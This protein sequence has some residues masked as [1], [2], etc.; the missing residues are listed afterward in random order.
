MTKHEDTTLLPAALR[1]S[2]GL[3]HA[4][5]CCDRVNLH[6]AR[7]SFGLDGVAFWRQFRA[8]PADDSALPSCARL[9]ANALP[10]PERRWIWRLEMVLM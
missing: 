4:L 5:K 1:L 2:E 10:Q 9:L 6:R 8:V 3:G 7:M